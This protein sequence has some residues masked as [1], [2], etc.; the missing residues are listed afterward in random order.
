MKILYTFVLSKL[1][2]F[3]KAKFNLS[4]EA[5]TAIQY[6]SVQPVYFYKAVGFT[7]IS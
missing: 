1:N 7:K 3:N 6:I 2:E 4:R 5:I